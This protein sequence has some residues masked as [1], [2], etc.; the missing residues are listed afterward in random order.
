MSDGTAS[1]RD[2]NRCSTLRDNAVCQQLATV[3][4]MQ[5][6]MEAASQGYGVALSSVSNKAT[7]ERNRAVSGSAMC[8]V[9]LASDSKQSSAV[10]GSEVLTVTAARSC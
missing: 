7:R 1:T 6:Q 4:V 5:L 3:T 8:T 9:P 2:S 10:G